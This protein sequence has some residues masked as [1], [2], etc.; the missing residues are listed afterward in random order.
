MNK[1]K[2]IQI[3]VLAIILSVIVISV[4]L[5]IQHS[6]THPSTD[7]ANIKNHINTISTQVSGKV[8]QLKIKN[9]SHVN[10]GDVLFT[11][12]EAPF[13]IALK[14]A[15]ATL[16]DAQQTLKSLHEK[17]K[18]EQAQ[19]EQ[20]KATLTNAKTTL[21]RLK[22]D[23]TESD[24][25]LD[26]AKT[27]VE[28][29]QAAL[30]STI[31]QAQATQAMLGTSDETN[32]KILLAKEGIKQAELNLSYCTIKTPTSGTINKMSLRPG[33]II[34]VNQPLFTIVHNENFW[35]Q[36]NFKETQL[37]HIKVGQ[38]ATIKID[39]YP[40]DTY[41]GKVE[42][43]STG[44]GSAFALLPAEN[45]TGNWVKVTQRVPVWISIDNAKQYRRQFFVGQSA[46]VTV[47]TSAH[48]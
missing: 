14:Q 39:S 9:H 28:I 43:F 35:V 27:Q 46:E 24:Q 7:D 48:E 25:T 47:D 41:R 21:K 20:Q 36:A 44:S 26:N 42:S 32:A 12:D 34:S 23:K 1:K 45:A 29:A 3:S 6:R 37:T 15:Q 18:S 4:Y 19:I 8:A 33:D 16:D 22:A 38:P 30:T 2:T 10:K 11:L 17:L 13:R 31:A 40:N 5:Y